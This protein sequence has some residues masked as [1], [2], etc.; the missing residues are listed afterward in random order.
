MPTAS[1]PSA[2]RRVMRLKGVVVNL[3][4]TFFFVG[5]GPPVRLYPPFA[6]PLP[7]DKGRP[8]QAKL[9]LYTKKQGPAP[10]KVRQDC[11]KFRIFARRGCLAP[12]FRGVMARI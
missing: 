10:F 7:R 2:P 5:E 1:D 8:R 3:P 4:S 11:Q 12:G 9:Q 6:R